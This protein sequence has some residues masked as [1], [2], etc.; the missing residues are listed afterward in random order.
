MKITIEN[1]QY[2]FKVLKC[3]FYMTFYNLNSVKLIP[4]P[5]PKKKMQEMAFQ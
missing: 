1:I 3:V 4:T 5:P 2:V